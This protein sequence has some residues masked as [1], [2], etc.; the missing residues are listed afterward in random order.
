MSD[1]RDGDTQQSG[2]DRAATATMTIRIAA[3]APLVIGGLA[4][5]APGVRAVLG[6]GVSLLIAGDL[7]GLRRWG[8]SLG[9]WAPVATTAL[10]VIQALAAPIP[11]VVVTATNSWLFGPL[12]GGVLS[13]VSATLA[14]SICY[15]IA[16]AL[17]EPVVRRLV[18]PAALDRA[19]AL[20]SRHG[21]IA[22]LVARLIPVVPFDPISY[23]A[24]L[25]RMSHWRFFWA[26]L[27]G[28]IPA[29][30]AYSYLAQEVRRPIRLA[31]AGSAVF[32]SLLIIGWVSR[33]LLLNGRR[34]GVKEGS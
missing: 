15:A 7:E 4:L 27:V 20:V 34:A 5:L 14:A 30:L 21:T 24:G 3:I 29:G 6:D 31:V 16:R 32:V 2:D 12:A 18:S 11:A 25:A 26:T 22:V 28:Q 17:G 8:A 13:I 1:L 19:D 10:M 23:L 33:R 9:P